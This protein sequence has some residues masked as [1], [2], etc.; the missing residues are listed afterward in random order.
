MGIKYL[1]IL[2]KKQI[3]QYCALDGEKKM[4][5]STGFYKT[6]GEI[7]GVRMVTLGK[8]IQLYYQNAPWC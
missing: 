6:V 8:L 1:Y 4:D 3:T 7:D 5:K 2:R